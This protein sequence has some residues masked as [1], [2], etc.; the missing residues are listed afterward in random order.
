MA[1]GQHPVEGFADRGIVRAGSEREKRNPVHVH[2]A[3]V[4]STY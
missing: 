1:A 2:E 4:A 3:G